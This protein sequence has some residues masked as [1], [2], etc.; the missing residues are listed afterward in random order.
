MMRWCAPRG[1]PER[2]TS[3]S[4]RAWARAVATVS[5]SIVSVS[6][7]SSTNSCRRFLFPA[8]RAPP[9]EE[10]GRGDG[11]DREV[12]A[13]GDRVIQGPP[14]ALGG[15]QSRR[16]EDQPV[17][18]RSSASSIER[19]APSSC[20]H[21]AS[22]RWARRRSFTARPDAAT[23]GVIRATDRPCRVTTNVSWRCS[24]ASSTSEK[25]PG[26]LGRGDVFHGIR[27][28]DFCA[29][30]LAPIPQPV[31]GVADIQARSSSSRSRSR[32]T[33]LGKPRRTPATAPLHPPEL[34]QPVAQLGAQVGGAADTNRRS[35]GSQSEANQRT[36]A[37]NEPSFAISGGV[38][39]GEGPSRRYAPRALNPS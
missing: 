1:R 19:I 23:A 21:A 31:A 24:T 12:V 30:L 10:L 18:S 4:S 25:R 15:H 26:C 6:S 34:E 9:H 8:R 16:V 7:A 20:S 13:I 38:S 36:S 29:Q 14:V 22:G 11:R 32:R 2:R 33:R 27:L 39:H 3:D 17:Q 28:S 5:S 37:S 35:T